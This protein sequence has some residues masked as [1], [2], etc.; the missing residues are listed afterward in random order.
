MLEYFKLITILLI[1]ATDLFGRLINT[2]GYLLKTF[3][4]FFVRKS[5]LFL[6]DDLAQD[7][8]ASYLLFSGA[9]I[10]FGKLFLGKSRLF[11]G[12]VIIG[13]RPLS[14]FNDSF[15]FIFDHRFGQFKFRFGYQSFKNLLIQLMFSPF[16]ITLFQVVGDGLF[17]VIQVF[18]LAQLFCKF[19]IDFR[20]LFFPNFVDGRL[21][22]YFVVG[23]LVI[24][25][26][27][28]K[29][30]LYFTACARLHA[31]YLFVELL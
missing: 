23:Q 5:Q 30:N 7:Q 28:G 9:S 3:F 26:V 15:Q 16:I 1:I 8:V 31:Y 2:G 20:Q 27:F 17:H 29:L 14:L 18:I 22:S 13:K 25:V 6:V 12:L 24:K 11:H 10:L 21:K 19:I 4:Q